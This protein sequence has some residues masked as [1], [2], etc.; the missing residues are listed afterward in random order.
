MFDLFV[1]SF[2]EQKRLSQDCRTSEDPVS[3]FESTL[4]SVF[5]EIHHSCC[6]QLRTLDPLREDNGLLFCGFRNTIASRGIL[7]FIGLLD[8]I[9]H[10]MSLMGILQK[11]WFTLRK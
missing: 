2:N 9:K 11:E 5:A 6:A 7:C 3:T 4:T 1:I 10:D 8:H